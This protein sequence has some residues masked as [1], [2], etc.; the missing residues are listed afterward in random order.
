MKK[1]FINELDFFLVTLTTISAILIYI[2]RIGFDNDISIILKSVSLSYIIILLPRLIY[3]S[4]SKSL[5][6]K[7]SLPLIIIPICS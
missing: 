2:A 6:K 7:F 4:I 3:N 1:N 5:K